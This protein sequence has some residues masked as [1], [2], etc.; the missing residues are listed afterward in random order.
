MSKGKGNE[1]PETKQAQPAIVYRSVAQ[2]QKEHVFSFNMTQKQAEFVKT[3]RKE[4]NFSE[5]FR[6][7]L[8]T[9]IAAHSPEQ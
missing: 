2:A 5:T 3:Y 9:I 8:D 6:K 7:Y 4:I 1:I